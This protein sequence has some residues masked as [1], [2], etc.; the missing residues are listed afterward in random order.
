MCGR[1]GIYFVNLQDISEGRG[2]DFRWYKWN[3]SLT[4]SF[5]LYY[6]PAVG[7]PS[8]KMSTRDNPEM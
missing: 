4:I 8:K 2:F 3:F 1:L 6:V 7:S 5:R